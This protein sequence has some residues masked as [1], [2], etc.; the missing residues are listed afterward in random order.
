MVAGY[1]LALAG[2]IKLY[3]GFLGLYFLRNSE[4]RVVWWSLIWGMVFVLISLALNGWLPYEQYLRKVLF[5]GF[6]PYAAEFN[7]SFVGF[8]QRLLVPSKFAIALADAP[9]LAWGLAAVC[10]LLTLLGCVWVGGNR[11]DATVQALRYS[12][13]LCAMLLLAPVNGVYNLVVL[14][15][16]VLVGMRALEIRPDHGLR[17]WLVI[18]LALT[19][20][21]PGW[22]NSLP[23]YTDV[24]TGWGILLLSP[25]LY[26]V[27]IIFMMMIRFYRHIVDYQPVGE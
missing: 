17:A 15:F 20:I 23:I 18:G 6:Y 24:H 5:G 22:S 7:I 12:V 16:P 19:C 26:G 9:W 2:M 27:V 21:P 1:S 3:P 8:F 25:A 11:P 13:Y 14:V 4:R 10:S